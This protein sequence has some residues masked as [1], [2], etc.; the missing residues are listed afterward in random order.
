MTFSGL[1]CTPS[2]NLATCP[3]DVGASLGEA[4]VDDPP[5]V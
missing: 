3:Q 2:L 4:T 1:L 5:P